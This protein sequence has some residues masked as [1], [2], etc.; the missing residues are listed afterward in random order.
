V[1]PG[2]VDTDMARDITLPKTPPAEIARDI[3]DV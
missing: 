2:P 3:L 1:F